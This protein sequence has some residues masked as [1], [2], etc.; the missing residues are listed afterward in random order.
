MFNLIFDFGNYNIF[1]AIYQIML[2]VIRKAY[3][4]SW[5][6]NRIFY[7]SST[8]ESKLNVSTKLPLFKEFDFSVW[9]LKANSYYSLSS[10]LDLIYMFFTFYITTYSL[11]TTT[12]K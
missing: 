5:V 2:Y 11:I 4:N 7:L 12:Y 8:E 3:K 1:Y 6:W 10:K 9:P